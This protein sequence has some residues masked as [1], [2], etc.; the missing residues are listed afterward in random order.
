MIIL[1]IH[2][3][4]THNLLFFRLSKFLPILLVISLFNIIDFILRCTCITSVQ[5]RKL[6]HLLSN[7]RTHFFSFLDS[8]FSQLP[9]TLH[10][11]MFAL[12]KLFIHIFWRFFFFEFIKCSI[13]QGFMPLRVPFD[14]RVGIEIL[15]LIS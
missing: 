12:F 5:I 9:H 3:S 7:I 4:S 13:H 2:F 10:D 8:T 11:F 14:Y 15:V 6:L 1:F